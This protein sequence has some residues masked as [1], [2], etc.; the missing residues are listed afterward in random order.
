MYLAPFWCAKGTLGAALGA[1]M[2][3]PSGIN[4]QTL[5]AKTLEY[6]AAGDIDPVENLELSMI[7]IYNGATGSHLGVVHADGST[8]VFESVHLET[9]IG[10]TSPTETGHMM[11]Y[12]MN[13]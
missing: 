7:Y 3:T 1:C 9:G 12:T 6:E 11:S 5:V 13:L 2:S 8:R 4:I 10:I